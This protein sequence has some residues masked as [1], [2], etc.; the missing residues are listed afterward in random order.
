MKVVRLE[1]LMGTFK[2]SLA[3]ANGRVQASDQKAYE[4]HGRYVHLLRVAHDKIKFH[5]KTYEFLKDPTRVPMMALMDPMDGYLAQRDPE[6]ARL[7]VELGM[8]HAQLQAETY[9]KMM[10]VARSADLEKRIE[11]VALAL[12]SPGMQGMLESDSDD[13]EED[14]KAKE[15]LR[16]KQLAKYQRPADGEQLQLSAPTGDPRSRIKAFESGAEIWTTGGQAPASSS[17][18]GASSGVA[19]ASSGV[20]GASSFGPGA[21]GPPSYGMPAWKFEYM[22]GPPGGSILGG[23]ARA[24]PPSSSGPAR[25]GGGGGSGVRRS[26]L[27]GGKGNGRGG[28]GAS[29]AEIAEVSARMSQLSASEA[30]DEESEARGDDSGTSQSSKASGGQTRT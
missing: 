23:G 21:M 12:S 28:G 22:Y 6:K 24:G 26:P 25:G 7:I 18:L 13:D 27:R 8:C 10:D 11:I 20:A 9:R 16:A 2:V 17:G 3:T 30:D 19:G 5:H 4:Q 29:G 15:R 14:R 1:K